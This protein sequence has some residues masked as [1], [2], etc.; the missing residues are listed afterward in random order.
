MNLYGNEEWHGRNAG[1]AHDIEAILGGAKTRSAVTRNWKDSDPGSTKA[2]TR[3]AV[4][5]NEKKESNPGST[6]ATTR[7]ACMKK[8]KPAKGCPG[9]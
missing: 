8:G 6:K 7:S 9:G 1:Y 2:T 5:H 3:S 4:D